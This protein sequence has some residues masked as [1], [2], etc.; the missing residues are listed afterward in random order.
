M[1]IDYS[2]PAPPTKF[3]ETVTVPAKLLLSLLFNDRRQHFN[4]VD[5]SSHLE[6]DFVFVYPEFA[7]LLKVID[8]D[9]EHVHI[10]YPGLFN[11]RETPCV[12]KSSAWRGGNSSRESRK[13]EQDRTRHIITK[14]NE[15]VAE[16]HAKL[17]TSGMFE[18]CE[19]G[20]L[21]AFYLAW[22]ITFMRNKG[23]ARALCDVDISGL[24][25]SV[26]EIIPVCDPEEM[27]PQL[28]K[29]EFVQKGK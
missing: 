15:V 16:L 8:P 2:I 6:K 13:R 23:M 5:N 19:Q 9:E 18:K 10:E 3:R 29:D 4:P 11:E 12:W 1:P 27:F 7:Q 25:K 22:R 21:Q 14:R 24:D 20:R 26:S 28:W 17:M